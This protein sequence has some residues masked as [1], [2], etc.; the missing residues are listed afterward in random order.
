MYQ[1]ERDRTGQ[2]KAVHESCCNKRTLLENWQ[3]LKWGLIV[4]MLSDELISGFDGCYLVIE[5]TSLVCRK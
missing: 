3:D 2:L 4:V 1:S 5:E